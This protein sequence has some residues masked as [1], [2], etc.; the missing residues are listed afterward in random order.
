MNRIFLGT[1]LGVLVATTA[2]FAAGHTAAEQRGYP[3]RAGLEKE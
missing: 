1:A 2:F 3:L